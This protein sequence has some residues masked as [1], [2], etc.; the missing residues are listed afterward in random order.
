MNCMR[1][2]DVIIPPYYI[3]EPT[4]FCNF[5]C[6]I[7]PN[8]EYAREAKGYMS[9]ELFVKII[10][11]IREYAEVIQLYWMGEPLLHNQIFQMI[12]YC[13]KNT[14]AKIMISTNGSLLTREVTDKLLAA[15]IDEII[16][17]MDAC[18]SQ[19]I[20]YKIRVGGDLSKLNE[21]VEYLLNSNRCA[22]IVL[23][24]IDMYINKSEKEGFVNKWSKYNCIINIQCIY[25][26]ANQLPS[27]NLTSDNTSPVANKKRVPCEDLWKKV[28]IRWD[29][30]LA[31]CCFDWSSKV[32]IGDLNSSSM[33]DLWNSKKINELRKY[34]LAGNYVKIP[35]CAECDS[36]AEP[37][38]YADLFHLNK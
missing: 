10:E 1:N 38:E 8:R 33:L 29:G 28:S 5:S 34:H 11:E 3:I 19:R 21:N 31:L 6:P 9:W 4:N 27:L 14:R 37:E 12:D 18:D 24:F 22:N 16:V 36:W 35:I 13:K 32:E 30:T 25:S 15:K 2:D 26:W 20:Y 7:C 23:Q 17:S